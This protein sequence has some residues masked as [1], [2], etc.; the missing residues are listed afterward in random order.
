MP[1]GYCCFLGE[2][3]DPTGRKVEIFPPLLGFKRLFAQPGR[4]VGGDRL[5]PEV[6]IDRAEGTGPR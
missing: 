3:T 6:P 4:K 1:H 2:A 5:Q